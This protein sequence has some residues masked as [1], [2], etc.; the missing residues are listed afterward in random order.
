MRNPK[1]THSSYY[2]ESYCFY[3]GFKLFETLPIMMMGLFVKLTASSVIYLRLKQ[4]RHILNALGK[5]FSLLLSVQFCKE[6]LGLSMFNGS[7]D[8][9]GIKKY[10]LKGRRVVLRAKATSSKR[11]APPCWE[12]LIVREEEISFD[13]L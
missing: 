3:P 2:Y 11:G 8:V 13:K 12:M 1:N 6:I 7:A 9:G 10:F 4:R 5:P